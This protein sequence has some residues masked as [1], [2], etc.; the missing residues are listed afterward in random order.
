MLQSRRLLTKEAATSIEA[1]L[2]IDSTEGATSIEAALLIGST[3]AA[4]SIESRAPVSVA[5]KVRPEG[6]QG[7]ERGEAERLA[8]GSSKTN[9]PALKG[10]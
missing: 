3:G 4:T 7:R 9:E 10:R 8:P 6:S 2:L 1:A 5:P